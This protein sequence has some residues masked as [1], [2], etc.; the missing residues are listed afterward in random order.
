M[1]DFVLYS[2]VFIWVNNVKVIPLLFLT[3]LESA[4][5]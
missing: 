3:F 5:W 4:P 1:S 2:G